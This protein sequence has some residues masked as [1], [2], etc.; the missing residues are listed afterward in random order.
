MYFDPP[1]RVKL[2]NTRGSS[3]VYCLNCGRLLTSTF[4][5]CCDDAGEQDCGCGY[6]NHFDLIGHKLWK[7]TLRKRRPRGELPSFDLVKKKFG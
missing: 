3:N 5:V 6:T 7:L 4:I 2:V 1:E